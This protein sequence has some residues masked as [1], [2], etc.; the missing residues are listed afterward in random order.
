MIK[1]KI[2]DEHVIE[3]LKNNPKFFIENSSLL[4]EILFPSDTK[5]FDKFEKGLDN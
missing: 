2:K 4:D 5:V 3:F 1:K